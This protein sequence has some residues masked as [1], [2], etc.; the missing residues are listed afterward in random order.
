MTIYNIN[1]PNPLQKI[2]SIPTHAFV[3]SF[4]INH[5]CDFRYDCPPWHLVKVTGNCI[6]DYNVVCSCICNLYLQLMS[7]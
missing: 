4:R 3:T 2:M 1:R 6:Y 7:I 5:F